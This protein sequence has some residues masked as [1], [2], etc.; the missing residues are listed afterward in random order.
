MARNIYI[1]AYDIS[2]NKTRKK[3]IRE[4]LLLGI[5]VQYSVFELMASSGEIQNFMKFANNIIDMKKD[6]VKIYKIN[7]KDYSMSSKFGSF[8]SL[9]SVND[10]YI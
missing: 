6:R 1:V 5:R 3:L 4:L 7:K 10:L 8:I 2:D 9:Q